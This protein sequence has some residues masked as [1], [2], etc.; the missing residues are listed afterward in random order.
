MKPCQNL[1]DKSENKEY[2]EAALYNS[3]AC[4]SHSGDLEKACQQYKRMIALF[5][6]GALVTQAYMMQALTYVDAARWVQAATIFNQLS[7]N[8]LHSP[9]GQ[10]A[11]R[12]ALESYKTEQI[13]RCSPNVAGI[14]SMLLPGAGQT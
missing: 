8:S 11:G 10:A 12:L 3:G 4:Y 5:P 1:V 2:V 6:K 14:M 13:P 9:I 7:E